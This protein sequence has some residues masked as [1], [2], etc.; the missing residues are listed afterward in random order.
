[1][2]L[3]FRKKAKIIIAFGSCAC[4]GGIH[5]LRKWKKN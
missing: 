2:A 1:M 4:F 3:E 5:G